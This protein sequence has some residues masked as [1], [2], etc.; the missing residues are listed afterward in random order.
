MS[1]EPINLVL[2]HLRALRREVGEVRDDVR[3][4]KVRLTRIDNTVI[5]LRREQ[6]SDAEGVAHL[7]GRLDRFG[8]RLSRIET[9]L[10]ILDS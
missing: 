6:A 2:E 1:E 10:D 4:I 9:R 8:E 3:D 7:E 5:T